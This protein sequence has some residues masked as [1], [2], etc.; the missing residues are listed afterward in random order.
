[1]IDEE[2][3]KIIQQ[4]YETAER[5]LTENKPKL[6]QIAEKLITLETIEGEKLEA[7]FNEPVVV[8]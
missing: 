7:L 5:I 6:I 2:V 3:N 4:A 8:Q 1:M